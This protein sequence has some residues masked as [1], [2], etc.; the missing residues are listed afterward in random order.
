MFARFGNRIGW[1]GES[2]VAEALCCAGNIVARAPGIDPS[3]SRGMTATIRTGSFRFTLAMLKAIV[4]VE[5]KIAGV[6]S[7]RRTCGIRAGVPRIR[8]K[9][10]SISPRSEGAMTADDHGYPYRPAVECI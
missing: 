9:T 7:N 6:C 1:T 8:P 4:S 2:A 5:L 10:A 3:K